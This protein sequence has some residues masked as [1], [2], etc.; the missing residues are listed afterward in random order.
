MLN[1]FEHRLRL[2]PRWIQW[3]VDVRQ[4]LWPVMIS[5][6]VAVVFKTKIRVKQLLCSVLSNQKLPA[7]VIATLSIRVSRLYAVFLVSIY[8]TRVCCFDFQVERGVFKWWNASLKLARKLNRFNRT[9]SFHK[10]KSIFI[11]FECVFV[12]VS[13]F[14]LFLD[15]TYFF[16]FVYFSYLSA[17]ISCVQ[18]NSV[19]FFSSFLSLLRKM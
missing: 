4:Q 9:I 1:S 3:I 12:F 10:S 13:T 16:P 11:Y 15:E 7:N 14:S 6:F 5:F 18:L 2:P 17:T 19:I 8:T